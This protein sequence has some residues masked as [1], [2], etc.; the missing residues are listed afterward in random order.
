[1]RVFHLLLRNS[2][3]TDGPEQGS[4]ESWA[5]QGKKSDFSDWAGYHWQ[6]A[7]G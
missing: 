6:I 5:A 3:Q 1:M 4:W 2:F 7:V